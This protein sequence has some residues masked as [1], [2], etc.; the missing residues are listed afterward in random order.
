VK[1]R[2]VCTGRPVRRV[3]NEPIGAACMAMFV[4]LVDTA[5]VIG[6]RVGARADDGT[7]PTMC[8][9]CARPGVCDDE[10]TGQA[11]NLE[12]LPGM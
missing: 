7:F 3:T 8:P 12:P 4:G 10:D 11:V 1:V 9:A 6:W 2:L 5:R